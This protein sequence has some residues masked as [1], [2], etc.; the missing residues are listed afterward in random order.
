MD[1]RHVGWTKLEAFQLFSPDGPLCQKIQKLDWS[2]SAPAFRFLPLFFPPTIRSFC[3]SAIR[4]RN[5][6]EDVGIENEV[7]AEIIPR[8]NA[9]T[10]TRVQISVS[11][12]LTPGVQEEISSLVLR[13]GPAL[14]SLEITKPLSEPA[15]LHAITLPNLREFSVHNRP[16]PKVPES[17]TIFPSLDR[18]NLTTVF[19][20]QWVSFIGSRP[21][22][23]SRTPMTNE[24]GTPHS[25]LQTLAP[26]SHGGS[27]PVAIGQ[28]PAFVN[29]TTLNIPGLCPG[30]GTC[31]FSLTD[32][33]VD[34]L[35]IALPRLTYL[36]LG[37]IRCGRNACKTT[38]RSY[39]SLSVYCS[40]LCYL[41][42]HINTDDILS[43]IRASLG[44]GDP[45]M[46]KPGPHRK[47]RLRLLD[48]NSTPLELPSHSDCESI[49]RGLLDVFPML[50]MI[51][52]WDEQGRNNMW[53]RV[54]QQISR[55]R[56][57]DM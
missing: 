9:S 7:L 21:S 38:F 54:Q 25:T 33:D 36:M 31:A 55:L 29:L 22:R 32:N 53:R 13:C 57:L 56:T 14:I 3:I 30:D 37:V 19:H 39:L 47:C 12:S 34:R 1:T 15:F 41:E 46:G 27:G 40:E 16:P 28:T 18:F 43:D 2:G 51:S 11:P 5:G 24:L 35:A 44:A 26:F 42:I 48:L 45:E 4:F 8:P 52:V 23:N 49:A 6:D 17:T 50:V 10:L 20:S